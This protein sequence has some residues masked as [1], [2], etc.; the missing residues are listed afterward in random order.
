MASTAALKALLAALRAE[1][2]K[3]AR[4]LGRPVGDVR[5]A[6]YAKLDEM[7]ERIKAAPGDV[8]PSPAQR[9]LAMQDLEQYLRD[10]RA[11]SKKSG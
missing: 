7:A 2:D 6:L 1:Q 10:F 5:E 4:R 9:A 8:E 11:G 3:R